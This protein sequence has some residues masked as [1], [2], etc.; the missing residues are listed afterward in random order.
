MGWTVR[1]WNPGEG[2]ISPSHTIRPAEAYTA[3]FTMGT[4]A[5]SRGVKRPGR[6]VGHPPHSSAEVKE[7]VELYLTPPTP[8]L[9][10]PV[11]G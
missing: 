1:G 7:R 5:L 4:G 8:A 3:S 2:E 9:L 6:G 11:V 10:S